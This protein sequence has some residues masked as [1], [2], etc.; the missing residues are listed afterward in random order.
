MLISIL[1]KEGVMFEK[2]M[3]VSGMRKSGELLKKLIEELESKSG[4]GVHDL[5][6]CNEE[7]KKLE[8]SI[9]KIRRFDESLL[10]Q[11]AYSYAMVTRVW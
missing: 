5:Q 3:I 2:E 10:K 4:L 11:P 6:Y 7:L 1:K 8:A 9:K